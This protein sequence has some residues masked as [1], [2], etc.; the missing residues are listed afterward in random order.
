MAVRTY[1]VVNAVLGAIRTVEHVLHIPGTTRAGE[2]DIHVAG[3]GEVLEVEVHEVIGE[4]SGDLAVQLMVGVKGAKARPDWPPLV[5]EADGLRGCPHDVTGFAQEG[6]RFGVGH[7]DAADLI[8]VLIRVRCQAEAHVIHG[9]HGLAVH[10][11]DR[12][13]TLPVAGAVERIHVGVVQQ[14]AARAG[15]GHLRALRGCHRGAGG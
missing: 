9:H 15:V 1:L 6:Q 5:K 4:I 12:E 13:R 7:G 2:E 3:A 11:H 10:R 8:T 14:L